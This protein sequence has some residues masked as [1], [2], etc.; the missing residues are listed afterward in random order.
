[1]DLG[2][3]G[4]RAA[5]AAGS[6]GLGY[7]VAAALAAEGVDVAVCGRDETRLSAAV[8]SLGEVATGAWPIGLVAD[9][10]APDA[11]VGFVQ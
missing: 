2:I 11:A 1:M 9:V 8:N 7:A 3:A 4:K 6:A 10:S 5:V